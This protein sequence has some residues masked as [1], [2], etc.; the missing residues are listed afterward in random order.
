MR[1]IVAGALIAVF[2]TGCDDEPT[3]DRFT[4]RDSAGITIA[5][6]SAPEWVT[7]EA[8]SLADVTHIDIGSSTE[9][10]HDL[11]D[12][13]GFVRLGEGRVAVAN[14]GSSEVR[15]FSDSGELLHSFGRAGEG[16]G[17]FRS[18]GRI[19]LLPG[20]SILV[21]DTRLDRLTIFSPAGAVVR[22][23]Q[24]EAPP[25]GTIPSPTVRLRD[26][27]LLAR[28]GFSF[29]SGSVSGV[30]QDTVP[31]L[32]YGAD[33][34][35][36]AELG[37]YPGPEY[38]V[39][40]GEGNVLGGERTW[41]LRSHVAAAG[42]GFIVGYSSD[43]SY[44]THDANGELVRMVRAH[45]PV[46]EVTAADIARVKEPSP[47]DDPANAAFWRR[48]LDAM[49]YPTRFPAY[50]AILTDADGYVWIRDYAWPEEGVPQEWQVFDRDGRWIGALTMPPGFSVMSIGRSEILGIYRDEVDVE[51]LHAY[52][53][54]R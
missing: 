4:V 15:I 16:P 48:V 53:L 37:R 43:Y 5:E 27:S 25:A 8:W 10:G 6:S 44:E 32:R 46:R 20:D 42:D 24:I 35:F 1:S 50:A 30:Y 17:E 34:S 3:A 36:I 40:A 12:V 9:P 47:D 7:R 49:E 23:A 22:T 38:F 26:G 41:G 13:T 54:S 11:Y 33:G 52:R 14:S 51:H 2:V 28:P 39:Y 45:R 21:T 29:G 19:F 31:L 18:M